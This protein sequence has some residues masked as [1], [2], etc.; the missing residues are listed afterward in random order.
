MQWCN[1]GSL[2]PPPPLFKQFSCLS[3][4]SSWDYRCVP[5][6]P[7]NFC[8]FSRDRV[9]LC[10]PA[11]L[12]FMPC[13]SP[14]LGLPEC[15]DSR[16]DSPRLAFNYL[17][18]IQKMFCFFFVSSQDLVLLPRLECNA[19][20]LAHHSLCLPGS[21]DSPFSISRVAGITGAHYHAQLILCV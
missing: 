12:E 17:F 21:S 6:H 8:I 19:A 1:L 7:A 14:N 2:Q 4:P 5:P 20:I 16:S 13:D 18:K 11:G 10:W 9:S 3:L 15:W